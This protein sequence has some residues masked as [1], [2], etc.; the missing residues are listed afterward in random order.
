MI[1]ATDGAEAGAGSAAAAVLYVLGVALMAVGLAGVAA[2][3][4]AGRHLLLRVACGI[5]GLLSFFVSYTVLD[6]I[7]KALVGDAG[8]AW[9]SDE[10]GI[11]VT[12]GMLAAAGLLNVQRAQ[13][14]RH[15][16]CAD[17]GAMRPRPS[18]RR[19]ASSDQ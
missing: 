17:A 18:A 14:S 9:L 19:A 1:A 7:A 11:L 4:A 3:L 15:T 12:G 5:G 10:A 2:A 13:L 8:P 16:V 6:G